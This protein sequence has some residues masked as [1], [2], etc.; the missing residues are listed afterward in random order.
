M[1]MGMC[2]GGSASFCYV[3]HVMFVPKSSPKWYFAVCIIIL[4]MKDFF[5]LRIGYI[6]TESDF[7]PVTIVLVWIYLSYLAPYTLVL[8]AVCSQYRISNFI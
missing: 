2:I 7:T 4:V 1:Y 6:P 8:A 5:E 3:A